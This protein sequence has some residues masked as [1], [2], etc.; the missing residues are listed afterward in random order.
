MIW[1]GRELEGGAENGQSLSTN[2]RNKLERRS[3]SLRMMRQ[4]INTQQNKTALS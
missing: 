1:L 2:I 3:E 4:H